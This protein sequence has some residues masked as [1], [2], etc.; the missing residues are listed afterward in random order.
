MKCCFVTAIGTNIGK[1][2]CSA[3]LLHHWRQRGMRTQALKP[4]MSGY[5]TDRLSESDAALLLQAQ[6]REAT[7]EAVAAISPWRFAAPLSPDMAAQREGKT[8]DFAQ[9]AGF[10]RRQ[11][12]TQQAD[13]LLAEGVGGV[14]APV[15]GGHTNRDLIQAL[16]WPVVLV[17]GSYV[18]TISHT[19]TAWAS[20][21]AVGITP[22][23]LVLSA[24]AESAASL[25]ETRESLCGFLPCGAVV[26][27][28]PRLA[29]AAKLWQHVADITQYL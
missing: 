6:G 14:M 23:L 16:G 20:L 15:A 2:L 7:A 21:E 27:T 17:A 8:I 12:E 26:A 24:S 11:Q 13:I 19:L 3:G 28:I 10:C 5:T 22:R 25:E 29:P 1:T 18:G 4:V 9:V